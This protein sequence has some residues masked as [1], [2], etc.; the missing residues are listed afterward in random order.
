MIIAAAIIGVLFLGVIFISLSRW[1]RNKRVE[2]KALGIRSQTEIFQT[3]TKVGPIMNVIKAYFGS[4]ISKQET[5]IGKSLAVL[6]ILFVSVFLIF[7]A[8]ITYSAI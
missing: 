2:L 3:G 8:Y 1:A 6:V 7:A 5:F 4:P